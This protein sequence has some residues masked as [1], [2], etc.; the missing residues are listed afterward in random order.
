MTLGTAAAALLA[1]C[2]PRPVSPVEGPAGPIVPDRPA[3]GPSPDVAFPVAEVATLSNGLEVDFLRAG[4]LPLLSLVLVVRAGQTT[5]PPGLPGLADFTAEM[6]KEGTR[7]RTGLELMSA[8]ED[9]GGSL[10]VYTD[11]DA[12]YLHVEIPT[13][14]A[15][16]AIAA[17]AE[18]VREPAFPAEEIEKHRAREQARLVRLRADPEYVA[19]VVLFRELYGEHP[20]ARVDASPEAIAL[21]QREHLVTFHG[22]RYAADGAF[23]VVAGDADP[24]ALRPALEAAFGGWRTGAAPDPAVPDPPA[25]ASRRVLLVDR[26]GS[27]QS[28]VRVGWATVPM[29]DPDFLRLAVANE[30]LGGSASSRLFLN[31]R[32]AHGYTYGAD[33]EIGETARFAPVVVRTNVDTAATGAALEEIVAELRGLREDPAPEEELLAR[34]AYMTRVFPLRLETPLSLAFMLAE[35]NVNG[36]PADFWDTYRDALGAVRAEEARRAAERQLHEDRAV[37]VVVG[38]KDEVLEGC[39]ALG[40]VTLTDVDGNRGETFPME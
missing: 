36:L 12:V 13:G 7:R 29:A 11:P 25:Q 23:L 22:D 32:E 14:S 27:V 8:I 19:E 30:I 6:L 5:E 38:V 39:R 17:L 2:G 28:V 31:L 10:G 18:M 34:V 40:S 4:R 9:A 33:S 3:L 15:A 20:Y 26:P 35:Q 37:I 21:L 24:P 1:S 16:A